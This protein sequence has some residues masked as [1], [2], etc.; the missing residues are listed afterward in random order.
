MTF[1]QYICNNEYTPGLGVIV[2]KSNKKSVAFLVVTMLTTG[3]FLFDTGDVYASVSRKGKTW[4][5]DEIAAVAGTNSSMT[6]NNT[7][8][9]VSGTV[10]KLI[11]NKGKPAVDGFSVSAVAIGGALNV[12]GNSRSYLQA[13]ILDK[14]K[15]H[16]GKKAV[17]TT[18]GDTEVYG[19][20]SNWT[21]YKIKD[22]YTGHTYHTLSS[23]DGKYNGVLQ[24]DGVLN[25]RGLALLAGGSA[26][27]NKGTISPFTTTSIELEDE[28]GKSV[29]NLNPAVMAGTYGN[30][31]A[32][33]TVFNGAL[34]GT[35]KSK[36]VLKNTKEKGVWLE[37][38]STAYLNGGRVYGSYSNDNREAMNNSKNYSALIF[39]NGSYLSANSVTFDKAIS[40]GQKGRINLYKSTLNGAIMST[41][42]SNVT[43]TDSNAFLKGISATG[44]EYDSSFQDNENIAIGIGADSALYLKGKTKA[45]VQS[46]GN[47]VD[48]YDGGT[49]SVDRDA[50]LQS[51]GFI[52]VDN[53][54]DF[55]G[56]SGT[57]S[58][59]RFISSGT[60][61]S[62]G[63]LVQNGG[64]ADLNGKKTVINKSVLDPDLLDTGIPFKINQ[65][66]VAAKDKDA[67]ITI[68][69]GI[70]NG[71]VAAIDSGK[72]ALNNTNVQGDA[73]YAQ[74]NG[75][76]ITVNGNTQQV[77][78]IKATDQGMISITNANISG[79]TLQA[80]GNGSSITLDGDTKQRYSNIQSISGTNE[81]KVYIS[82]G[83]LE[84]DFLRAITSES[85][86]KGIVLDSNGQIKTKTGEIFANGIETTTNQA[87]RDSKDSGDVTNHKIDFHGG[88]VIFT[89]NKY[90][91][92]YVNSTSGKLGLNTKIT[93]TGQRIEGDVKD[94]SEIAQTPDVLLDGV[95]ANSQGTSLVVG[96][97]A[98]ASHITD[99]SGVAVTEDTQ[100][101]EN[102]F[103]ASSLN[104]QQGVNNPSLIITNNREVSLGGTYEGSLIH[105]GDEDNY[106][107]AKIIVGT[108]QPFSSEGNTLVGNLHLGDKALSQ[109]KNFYINGDIQINNGEVTVDA[110]NVTVDSIFA[111]SGNL[112]VSS[113]A[114]LRSKNGIT[115]SEYGQIMT[116]KGSNLTV[117]NLIV[118]NDTFSSAF[119]YLGGHVQLNNTIL[120]NYA[121]MY[122]SGEGNFGNINIQGTS[123]LLDFDGSTGKEIYTANSI[124]TNKKSQLQIENGI[125]SAPTLRKMTSKA[126]DGSVLLKNTGVLKTTTGQVLAKGIN[127][128]SDKKAKDS[129]GAGSITNKKISFAG[130]TVHFTDSRYGE[131]YLDSARKA[132]QGT[133][134]T[135]YTL[136]GKYVDGKSIDVVKAANNNKVLRDKVTINSGKKNLV[137]GY[138]S[139][140]GR[141]FTDSG[142]KIEKSKANFVSNGFRA[143]K[144]NLGKYSNG[145][146]ITNG[147]YVTL[148][149]STSGDLIT[150]DNKR[151]P[152]K[153][154]VGLNKNITKNKKE[155]T[156]G[157]LYFGDNAVGLNSK[158]T[159]NGDI[160][161]NKGSELRTVTG[162][163][164]VNSISANGLVT[165]NNNATL[166]ITNYWGYNGSIL[167]NSGAFKANL[168]TAKANTTGKLMGEGKT[169]IQNLNLQDNSKFILGSSADLQVSAFHSG[170]NSLLEVNNSQIQGGS[171]SF[172]NS[173][174]KSGQSSQITGDIILNNNSTA[175][176][177][178]STVNGNLLIDNSSSANFG[179]GDVEITNILTNHGNINA[180][181][182]YLS[183]D[184]IELSGSNSS[185]T[186]QGTSLNSNHINISN[187]GWLYAQDSTINGDEISINPD[188]NVSSNSVAS[189][190]DSNLTDTGIVVDGEGDVNIA[191]GT[192]SLNRFIV[193][194]GYGSISN[195]TVYIKDGGAIG[196]GISGCIWFQGRSILKGDNLWDVMH[197]SWD[198][199]D[200]TVVP[201]DKSI[202][203]DSET[204]VDTQFN[205]IFKNNTLNEKLDYTHGKYVLHGDYT[206]NS[207]KQAENLL[208]DN[209]YYNG[210]SK[211]ILLGHNVM[212]NGEI[213]TDMTTDEA[214]G[215]PNFLLDNVTVHSTDGQLVQNLNASH[216]DAENQ[217]D[218]YIRNGASI[219][220]ASQDSGRVVTNTM[221]N[222][223]DIH[224]GD[225]TSDS[226][227]AGNLTV[228]DWYYGKN[229]NYQFGNL[230]VTD[231]GSVTLNPG[232]YTFDS[233]NVSGKIDIDTDYYG[234]ENTKIETYVTAPQVHLT[235]NQANFSMNNAALTGNINVENGGTFYAYDSQVIGD[236]TGGYDGNIIFTGSSIQG[237]L[238]TDYAEDIELSNT[239]ISN[240]Y[241]SVYIKDTKK[242]HF[243]DNVSIEG[244]LVLENSPI[245]LVDE[246]S[247][248]AK[249]ITIKGTGGLY[250]DTDKGTDSSGSTITA[251]T[252]TI[253]ENNSY[254]GQAN[255]TM[256]RV[257]LT[258]DDKDAYRLYVDMGST[259]VIN[260]LNLSN[261]YL[262]VS[263]N[264]KLTINN[265][266]N[267]GTSNYGG[268]ID[269]SKNQDAKILA[270][271]GT[272]TA[273]HVKI[274]N[275][276]LIAQN[277]NSN[278]PGVI[279]HFDGSIYNNRIVAT[280]TGSSITLNGR[281]GSNTVFAPKVALGGT[282]GAKIYIYGG[283]L[284]ADS[285]RKITSAPIQI[286]NVNQ[287][288]DSK[289]IILNSDG[290]IQTLTGQLFAK[291][292]NTSSDKAAKAST[293]AGNMT[294]GKIDLQKGNVLFDDKR[295]GEKYLASAAKTMSKYKNVWFTM[296]G[297]YVDSKTISP[298]TAIKNEKV[299]RDKVTVNSS[300]K[301]IVV[302]IDLKKKSTFTENGV[303]IDKNNSE[304]VSSG[305]RASKLN[306]ASGSNGLIITGGK[307]LTLG[308]SQSGELLTTGN[309]KGKWNIVIGTTKNR[310]GKSGNTTGRLVLG[311][312]A[313]G[314]NAK[315]SVSGTVLINKNS[316][317]E[318]IGNTMS[319]DTIYNKGTMY[320]HKISNMNVKNLQMYDGSS[321][322]G[323]G[324]SN[325][326]KLAIMPKSTVTFTGNLNTNV[327]ELDINNNYNAYFGNRLNAKTIK[328]NHAYVAVTNGGIISV[329]NMEVSNGYFELQGANPYELINRK[330]ADVSINK[331]GLFD[332]T[333][334]H[335]YPNSELKFGEDAKVYLKNNSK[336]V[337][338]SN[339]NVS[340]GD[341]SEIHV[342]ADDNK[343]VKNAITVPEGENTA[344]NISDSS[345]LVVANAV[346]DGSVYNLSNV[347]QGSSSMWKQ[348]YGNDTNFIE[349][350]KVNDDLHYKFEVIPVQ[351]MRKRFAKLMTANTVAATLNTTNKMNG[352]DSAYHNDTTNVVTQNNDLTQSEKARN[353]IVSVSKVG[354]PVEQTVT[355][356][357]HLA[358]LNGLAMVKRGLYS[359]A[360][361][362]GDAVIDHQVDDSNV[363]AGFLRNDE[364]SNG[365]KIGTMHDGYKLNY[366]GAIVGYDLHKTGTSRTG[367]AI[368]Y[369]DGDSYTKDANSTKDDM[370]YYSG[371]VYHMKDYGNL[372]I[373]L[374]AGYVH[375]S[376]DIS[377]WNA[378]QHL[379][380]STHGNGVTAGIY[381]N[382]RYQ[383]G[384]QTLAPFMGLRYMHLQNND[385]TDSFGFRHQSESLNTWKLPV[386]VVYEYNHKTENWNVSP[387]LKIGYSFAIGDKGYRDSFGF[388]NGLDSFEVDVAENSWFVEPGIEI[389]KNALSLGAY[390]RYQKGD[391]ISSRDWKVQLGYKF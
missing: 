324:I 224:V 129:T 33:N 73:L 43:L 19:N 381:L 238:N 352:V 152:V 309:K 128:S 72:I 298:A 276:D 230:Y 247:L 374:D 211:F 140:D 183:A 380:A 114:S 91:D 2:M 192:H 349:G 226:S 173:T 57:H 24:S 198:D 296:N 94:V 23:K 293:N 163:T 12:E 340:F 244:N 330:S 6:Y 146:V 85:D 227:D 134:N 307:T 191:G 3:L 175:Q 290:I 182:T 289:S 86:D 313:V 4:N 169:V 170:K 87:V 231:N 34:Y 122:V 322:N 278:I 271:G 337:A 48:I 256:D 54:D 347:V 123:S 306:L 270:K 185:L 120:K 184:T 139:K 16:I 186:L 210:E 378:G 27:I 269:N 386:G 333:E 59:G 339:T 113:A 355:S 375:S 195:A 40:A 147:R 360:G 176:L 239:T 250:T 338:E 373:I 363:W 350:K 56:L 249:N 68:A 155:V 368:A 131:K 76:K 358:G 379:T 315:N 65:L 344:I 300:K 63:F 219:F 52:Q 370:K 58:S 144:L 225:S 288:A 135:W 196:S 341:D 220:L 181:G 367:L 303:K 193:K 64:K 107:N 99:E 156:K 252:I 258:G 235:G 88:T 369:A 8:G 25:S 240:K 62:N 7:K 275:T 222:L 245:M 18:Y 229:T 133:R 60:V 77:M 171:L 308:G 42:G 266:A 301:N 96:T 272:I 371:E 251:N 118:G 234:T 384:S 202:H 90:T 1:L 189:F 263:N 100:F 49:I 365:I 215:L 248:K 108:T 93:M 382:K 141:N 274:L 343:N 111:N 299:L 383:M 302:G 294:N 335:V 351:T 283:I 17:V 364:S 180:Q 223:P 145:I 197:Q 388:G 109:G 143:S 334:I 246:S 295:Y 80:D 154:A 199:N 206:R 153:I 117:P 26:T 354:T 162:N 150:V 125:F 259:A 15:I 254:K 45:L 127:T 318:Q 61:V 232:R 9:Y 385:F 233:I 22:Y 317:L 366:N 292:I 110:G 102:G 11:D 311:D 214:A 348:I 205:Q 310:L 391:D 97:A 148:G 179:D 331:K 237:N 130:G 188:G 217:N 332:N 20:R 280:G 50:T 95:M 44:S 387:R 213:V 37:T 190:A 79:A 327:N 336:I 112:L 200:K 69:N 312:G 236:V 126:A 32:T 203:I 13:G 305:F 281:N 46:D 66:A 115:L 221:G 262:R 74:G 151:Q 204:R 194:S 70:I 105:V 149:G 82:G 78:E 138:S 325:I 297:K 132:M 160:F 304:F 75:S 267:L 314:T 83:T 265:W 28:T 161:V 228:G 243:L 31:R 106:Q 209:G 357:N 53:Q 323:W 71:V 241:N 137:I 81:G 390:F 165:V 30:L 167:R 212:D 285:L 104:L 124:T 121:Q 29:G 359:F 168:F 353:Y 242:G 253:N 51:D 38:G 342:E 328:G 284:K 14:G 10:L 321:F 320:I 264:A 119:A 187:G 329:D 207:V 345:K 177:S 389:S 201:E 116:E 5:E 142:V 356:L 208:S 103:R 286:Q 174:L 362:V 376:N 319:L 216:L 166:N 55:M 268:V 377:Q 261:G 277:N 92:N 158:Y 260:Q 279:S 346:I 218:V 257:N 291:G 282:N 47:P 84:S 316:T 326:A 157:Y 41:E 255:V 164:Y 361:I 273:N 172:S 67:S 136:S 98:N 372:Q 21:G 35:N 287:K 159:L 36:F 178:G 39:D 89:D 101:I